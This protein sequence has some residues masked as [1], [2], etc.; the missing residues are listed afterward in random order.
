M[1]IHDEIKNA[2]KNAIHEVG[3]AQSRLGF[4]KSKIST[5]IEG[6]V[7]SPDKKL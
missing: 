7:F 3:G 2:I 1:L 5:F 4:G 6:H